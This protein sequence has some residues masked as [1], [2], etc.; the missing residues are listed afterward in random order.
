MNVV[1]SVYLNKGYPTINESNPHQLTSS[2]SILFVNQLEYIEINS[3]DFS[4]EDDSV[5]GGDVVT[6]RSVSQISLP[7]GLTIQL[8]SQEWG[9]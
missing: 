5:G 2:P 1:Y 6:I 8:P 9:Y 7:E 3:S 4:I